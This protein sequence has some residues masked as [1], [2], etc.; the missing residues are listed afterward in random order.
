MFR[1][2]LFASQADPL[3]GAGGRAGDRL[4]RVAKSDCGQGVRVGAEDWMLIGKDA[5]EAANDTARSWRRRCA[6]AQ[7]RLHSHRLRRFDFFH[8]VGDE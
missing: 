4:A 2:I 3:A 6:V 8:R 5:A 7:D 1:S